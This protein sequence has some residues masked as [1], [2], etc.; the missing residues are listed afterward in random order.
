MQGYLG[1]R[2][3]TVV[4]ADN[5]EE[6]EEVPMTPREARA[7]ARA[8]GRQEIREYNAWRVPGADGPI[9]DCSDARYAA[10]EAALD[11]EEKED[12]EDAEDEE[13]A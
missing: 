2:M 9:T 11:A 5:E 3:A 4:E 8:A 10:L 12:E 1:A 7:Q 6:G 13:E